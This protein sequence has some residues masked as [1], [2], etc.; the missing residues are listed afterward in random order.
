MRVRHP[1]GSRLGS[2]C[3]SSFWSSQI[4]PGVQAVSVRLNKEAFSRHAHDTYTVVVTTAGVQEFYYRGSTHR[5][6]PGDVVVLHPGEVHDGRSG[7]DGPFAYMGLQIASESARQHLLRAT[8][9]GSLPFSSNPVLRNERLANLIRLAVSVPPDEILSESV[10]NDVM[11][12]L[13][14]AGT[15]T[16][17]AVKRRRNSQVE[18]A[19]QFLRAHAAAPIGLKDLEQACGLSASEMCRQFKLHFGTSPYR[20]LLM[21]RVDL[22]AAKIR[23]GETL[24]DVAASVGFTDQPHMN[25][26]F[27]MFVG[28]TPGSYA[29][30]HRCGS[31]ETP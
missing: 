28:L 3:A 11:G 31:P 1:V 15:C 10:L 30:L 25:R 7:G 6:L 19:E 29:A 5:S 27:R 4:A 22:A 16:P 2:S 26:T 17:S 8:S 13:C 12:E 24:A 9:S 20:Y 21:R 18:A 23:S 14:V